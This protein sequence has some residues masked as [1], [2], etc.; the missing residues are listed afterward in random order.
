MARDG[1][2]KAD[3]LEG[4]RKADTLYGLGGDDKISGHKGNDFIDG[5]TGNDKIG[6]GE[7]RDTLTGGAGKDTF[8]FRSYAKTDY[9][10]VTDFKHGVDKIAFDFVV[11]DGAKAGAIPKGDFYAGTK[12]HDADDRFVYDQKSGKLFYDADGSGSEAQHLVA[13]LKHSPTLTFSDFLFFH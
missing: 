1:T 4:S 13:V 10:T 7:G 2:N 9:D 3:Q 11:F 12:A 8:H 5:G 6:G